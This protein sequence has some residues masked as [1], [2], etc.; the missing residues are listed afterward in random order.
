MAPEVAAG[1]AATSVVGRQ[2]LASPSEAGHNRPVARSPES[3]PC[4]L[5]P[6]APA[7]GLSRSRATA[8]SV[9]GRQP[10][11]SPSEA[12]HNRPVARSP[13]SPPC[14]LPPSAPGAGAEPVP[15]Y[16]LETFLG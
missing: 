4:P 16:R 9:V 14:P 6:S 5:P 15:G 10:L 2:P 8:T 11:A 7:P 1:N 3:P 12:G 13:E